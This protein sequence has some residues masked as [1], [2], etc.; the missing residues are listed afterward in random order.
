MAEALRRRAIP[1]FTAADAEL[2]GAS[3]D[4]SLGHSLINA[5]VV[6]THDSDFLR[7]HREGHRHGGI[8]FAEQQTR[9]IGELVS[10]L[11][12][13]YEVSRSKRDGRAG[14][15]Y[16]EVL[17]AAP[18]ACTAHQ[19]NRSWNASARSRE[20]CIF[21]ASNSLRA[22]SRWSRAWSR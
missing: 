16:L 1:G 14:G 8:A 4:A 15:V 22:K 5:R 7:L 12:L 10:R 9:S 6:V 21:M 11:V 18:E 13:I 17:R 3:D 20:G 19:R 2:L